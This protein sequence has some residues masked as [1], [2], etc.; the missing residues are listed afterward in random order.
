MVRPIEIQDNLSKAPLAAR[1]QHLQ[2]ANAQAAQ[3]Q[4]DAEVTEVRVLDQS[5]AVPLDETSPGRLAVGDRTPTG[6]HP[7][8]NT[9][10]RPQPSEPE[11]H[12]TPPAADQN[13][14]ERIDF[15]A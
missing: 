12:T 8:S 13:V 11:A 15:L 4:V 3:Q 6:G 2:Q 7:T 14:S 1:E 10:H 5:R 9:E